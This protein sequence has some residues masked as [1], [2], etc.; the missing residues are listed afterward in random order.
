[1][2]RYTHQIRVADNGTTITVEPVE[3]PIIVGDVVSWVLT[4]DSEPGAA[5]NIL[6][7]DASPFNPTQ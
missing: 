7:G 3:K 1:M 6:F 4:P 2:G 5:I